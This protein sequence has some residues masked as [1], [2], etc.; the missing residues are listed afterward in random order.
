MTI[1]GGDAFWVVIGFQRRENFSQN[2]DSAV[3]PPGTRAS[4]Q[5]P[6]SA[7]LVWMKARRISIT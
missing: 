4:E 6:P 7:C 2:K 1:L 3:R 5:G